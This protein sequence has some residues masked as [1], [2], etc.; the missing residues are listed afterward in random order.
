MCAIWSVIA[1]WVVAIAALLGAIA[2]CLGVNTWKKQNEWQANRDL[3]QRLVIA[4]GVYR[5]AVLSARRPVTDRETSVGDLDSDTVPDDVSDKGLYAAFVTRLKQ[6]REARNELDGL[7][8]ETDAFWKPA[9]R[10]KFE[11]I[12]KQ[13][14]DL[15]LGVDNLLNSLREDDPDTARGFAELIDE[16]V[17]YDKLSDSDEFRAKFDKTLS[18]VHSY[19]AAKVG[20]L[21]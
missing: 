20:K 11:A 19:L 5:S 1:D 17:L 10:S 16:R 3:V 2:A 18:D 4:L 9:I 6:I 15:T 13:E 8:L 7:F 21:K 12:T 14:I